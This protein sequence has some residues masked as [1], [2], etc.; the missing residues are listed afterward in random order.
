MANIVQK[1]AQHW[2]ILF[3][4]FPDWLIPMIKI[5]PQ[6]YTDDLHNLLDS[7]VNFYYDFNYFWQKIDNLNYKLYLYVNGQATVEYINIPLYVD[8]SCWIIND[9]FRNSV[10]HQ[11]G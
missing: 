3:E 5:V 11:L 8:V 9:N 4:N 6:F 1:D 7:S 10:Q 2:E